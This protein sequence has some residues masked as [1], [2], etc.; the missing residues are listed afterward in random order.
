VADP[1]QGWNRLALQRLERRSRKRGAAA[2]IGGQERYVASG[3]TVILGGLTRLRCD[4]LPLAQST[5]GA[6]PVPQAEPPPRTPQ[7][8][9]GV[10]ALTSRSSGPVKIPAH[11]RLAAQFTPTAAGGPNGTAQP[12]NWASSGKVGARHDRHHRCSSRWLVSLQPLHT[13]LLDIRAGQRPDESGQH[14]GWDPTSYRITHRRRTRPC[15][16]TRLRRSQA[17]DRGS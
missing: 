16:L 3:T 13:P 8:S 10:R 4:R 2:P 6:R 14:D 11:T 17:C 15:D 5:S 7:V 1:T 12:R 9:S